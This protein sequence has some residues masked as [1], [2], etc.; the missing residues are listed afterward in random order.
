MIPKQE[1]GILI[2]RKSEGNSD[3]FHDRYDS[4]SSITQ[5][6]IAMTKYKAQGINIYYFSD[7]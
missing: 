2:E 6:V 7:I 1:S 5:T 4:G 3:D